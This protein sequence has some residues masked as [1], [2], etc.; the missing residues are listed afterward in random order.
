MSTIKLVISDLHLAD[1]HPILEGFGDTQQAAVEGLVKAA[2]SNGPLGDAED[3][4]LIIN[5]DCFDFLAVQPYAADGT[6]NVVTDLGKLE[7]IVSV[8]RAFFETLLYFISLPGRHVTFLRG[9]HDIELIFEEVQAGILAAIYG[10]QSQGQRVNFCHTPFYRPLKDV[11]IE[12]G[13]QYDFW[14]HAGDT[15]DEQGQPLQ[16]KPGVITLPVGTQYFQRASHAI[17]VQYPY[18]DHFEPAMDTISQRALLCLLNSGRGVWERLAW[19]PKLYKK[20]C[21]HET[22]V[23]GRQRGK[24]NLWRRR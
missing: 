18:F 4:E 13:N 11:Y 8:H 5:G 2:S 1:G 6:I 14:N 17:S 10:T 20:M 24:K 21:S 16:P 15:W 19:I 23:G 7:K 3:V 22:T 9:N 12:H